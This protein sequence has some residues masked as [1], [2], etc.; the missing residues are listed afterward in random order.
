M[1]WRWDQGRSSYF[2]FDSIKRIA[3]VL[4]KYNGADM[5]IVDEQLRK[6]LMKATGLPF[7]PPTYTIKRNYKRVFE[8][9]MLASYINN[10][11]IIS[12]IG[13]AVADS[14]SDLSHVDNYLYEIERRFRYPFPAFNNYND[15][16]KKC[17]PFLAILKFLLSRAIMLNNP[18]ASISLQDVGA[19]LIANEITGLED[20]NFYISLQSNKKFNFESYGSN[21]QKRQVREMMHFIGQHSFIESSENHLTLLSLKIDDCKKAFNSLNP[22]SNDDMSTSPIDDFMKITSYKRIKG[23]FEGIEDVEEFSVEEGKKVFKSH[24]QYE[25]NSKLRKEYIKRNPNPVCDVCGKDMH[26][27]YPWTENMLEIH[28]IH[29]LSSYTDTSGNHESDIKD[30]VGICPS[31][32]RA[33]HLYYKKYLIE[34][35]LKDFESKEKAEEKYKEAKNIVRN[36][37]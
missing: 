21:D 24:F 8:C 4:I 32:H 13:R 30:V 28:H 20:L 18:R 16:K 7:A 10:R 2:Q 29:P 6:D 33:I 26:I 3:A 17:F 19:F 5:K 36:N 34:E 22:I 25:R 1:I 14:N 11:L 23:E 12:E 37:V 31:C 27:I 35:N 9:M 15:V